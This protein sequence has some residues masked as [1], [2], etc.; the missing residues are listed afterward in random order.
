MA[1]RLGFNRGECQSYFE[2]FENILM[3]NE[4]FDKPASIFNEDEIG[5]QL[6]NKANFVLVERGS[7]VLSTD[8]FSEKKETISLLV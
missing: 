5:L 2:L 3:E 4:L 1:R 7:K 6:N 8:L